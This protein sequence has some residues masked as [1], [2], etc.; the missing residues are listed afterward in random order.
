MHLHPSSPAARST[1]LDSDSAP[2]RRPSIRAL[3]Y[4]S[5]GVVT[6]LAILIAI[7]I[8]IAKL[9]QTSDRAIERLPRPLDD[10]AFAVLWLTSLLFV[11]GM[12]AWHRRT[13][14]Q[15][16]VERELRIRL[17]HEARASREKDARVQK[18][19]RLLHSPEELQI[20]YQPIV[21]LASRRIDGY[22]ALSRFP[23]GASPEIWFSRA[24]Q[25]GMLEALEKL[26][27][28]RALEGLPKLPQSAYLSINVSPSTLL[29]RSFFALFSGVPAERIVLELT[30]HLRIDEYAAHRAVVAKLH[31]LGLRFAVDDAGAGWA[32]LRHILRLRP[33]IVKADRELLA[34]FP[35][36]PV[37]TALLKGLAEFIHAIPGAIIIAEGVETEA[38]VAL[39]RKLNINVGQGFLLGR[40]EPLQ[41][42]T[43]GSAMSASDSQRG[44]LLPAPLTRPVSGC[45][46]SRSPTP[47]SDLRGSAPSSPN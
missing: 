25:V 13:L 12:Y 26:A 46:P 21:A 10:I 18:I 47:A 8:D 22:E 4:L 43:S 19:E 11:M 29:D 35:D 33:D 27:I 3:E 16:R 6:I 15:R 44:G 1:E 7:A 37:P 31:R 34:G 45:L 9:D 32:S 2:T 24:A 5:A 23:D 41:A 42:L 39:L 28:T 17:R 14:S 36:D 20:L 40:P 38:Q 30:E